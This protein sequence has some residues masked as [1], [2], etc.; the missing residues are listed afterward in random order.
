M[1]SFLKC[2]FATFHFYFLLDLFRTALSP[3]ML[4]FF[5]FCAMA[6]SSLYFI[7]I[8]P[9]SELSSEIKAFSKDF[10]DRFESVKSWKNFPHM[11]IIPPF[12]SKVENE[13]QL[14]ESFSNLPLTTK[15]FELKLLGFDCF[16]NK[17]NPVIFLKP[18]Q[19]PE[20]FHLAAELKNYYTPEKT[21]YKPHLTVAYRDLTREN[22]EKAWKEY[23]Q[24]EFTAEFLVDKVGLY[25]HIDG[26]WNL[27][28]SNYLKE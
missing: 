3:K 7:A 24:K 15:S 27:V 6:T 4:Q 17:N 25:K 20:L 13:E 11:T 5:Y 10:A 8:A 21:N 18:E 26:K 23:S 16:D 28:A 2:I 9:N 19:K 12:W 14:L 1:V 22:F